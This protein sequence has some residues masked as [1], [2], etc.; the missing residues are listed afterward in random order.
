MNIENLNNHK[1]RVES[2]AQVDELFELYKKINPDAIK[3][4]AF[5]KDYCQ[6]FAIY[7]SGIKAGAVGITSVVADHCKEIS[8]QEMVSKLKNNMKEKTHNIELTEKE[9]YYIRALF[10]GSNPMYRCEI[11]QEMGNRHLKKY[12]R[13]HDIH[14]SVGI[15]KKFDN[16]CQNNGIKDSI[17]APEVKTF[18]FKNGVIAEIHSK[19]K[20][21]IGCKEYTKDY[22]LE[23]YLPMFNYVDAIMLEELTFKK[24]ECL[25]FAKILK[26]I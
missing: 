2:Q 1:C 9:I 18:K 5:H 14:F 23:K 6:V 25:E 20:I 12:I 16:Y 8:Y 3:G 13:E 26:E 19:D 15:F 24:S 4:N 22:L 17:F 11:I 7:N 21:N 10:G